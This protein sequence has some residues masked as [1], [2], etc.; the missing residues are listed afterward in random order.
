MR[1]RRF[2]DRELLV[3]TSSNGPLDPGRGRG[4]HAS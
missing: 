3:P 1:R 4:T 2:A